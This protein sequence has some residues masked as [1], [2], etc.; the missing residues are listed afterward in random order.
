[1]QALIHCLKSE[2][3]PREGLGMD[4]LSLEVG[5]DKG[6]DLAFSLIVHHVSDFITGFK[7]FPVMVCHATCDYHHSPRVL[8][9]CLV[10]CI[11]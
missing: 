5:I 8:P 1:M 4:Q 2:N 7:L 6:Y 11:S 3:I 10:D 9:G